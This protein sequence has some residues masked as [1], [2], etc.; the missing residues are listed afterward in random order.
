M[1]QVAFSTLSCPNWTWEDLLE[2]GP[3]HGYDGVEVRLLERETDLLKVPE[4]Q[5]GA[6]AQRRRELD[7]AGFEVCGLASSVRFDEPERSQRAQQITTGRAYVDLAVELGAKFVRVFGDVLPAEDRPGERN[8]V[9]C[10]V[11]EGIDELSEYAESAGISILLETHGDFLDSSVVRQTMLQVNSPAAGVL[12]D[13]HHPWYF[14]DETVAQ[15]FEALGPWVR[16]T[17]WKDSIPS[18]ATQQNEATQAAAAEAHKLMSGHRHANYVLFGE[19]EFPALEC[20]RRL[21][22]AGYTGWFCYEWE[23]MWHPEIEDPEIAL[24][25]FPNRLRELWQSAEPS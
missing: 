1:P 9:I 17:H 6:L 14:C 23:R 19:G 11:A 22:E 13:T 3:R 5:P 8:A 10:Q 20:M 4:F 15:T 12:W 2:Q 18:K 25:P 21:R 24:P 7:S 16:H